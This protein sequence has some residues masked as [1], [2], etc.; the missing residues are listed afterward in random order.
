MIINIRGTNGS[1]KS[2]I[3]RGFLERFPTRPLFGIKGPR[4]PEA[5]QVDVGGS[6]PL[7]VLGPYHS[8]TGGVDALSGLG[9]GEVLK[10]IEKYAA[11]GHV[12]FES[13]VLS[14]AVGQI[15]EWLIAHKGESFVV[16]L[17]TPLDV[18][19][20]SIK[21]RTGSASRTA[22]VAEKFKRIT[23]ACLRLASE[24]VPVLTVSR[25]RAGD[26]IIKRLS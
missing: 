24:G 2:T 15:G 5:Y 4:Y 17:D 16:Q 21:A 19:L 8:L 10:L 13:V 9:F 14:T 18:C 7:F 1:G 23:Q 6:R 12:L 26:E 11:R 22:H 3:V 20:A 25:E